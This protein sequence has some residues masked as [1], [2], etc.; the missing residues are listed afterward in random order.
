MFFSF[1]TRFLQKKSLTDDTLQQESPALQLT[2]FQEIAEEADGLFYKNFDLFYQD[3]ATQIDLLVFIP[4][5]GIYFGEKI[6]WD[7]ATLNGAKI[8]RASNK[9]KKRSST[10]L[11]TTETLLHNKLEAILSF[12]STPI[13]RFIWMPSLKEEDFDTLDSSFHELLPKERLIF[14]NTSKESM[15]QK[16]T[17]LITQRNEP[18]ATL[19]VMGSLQSHTLLLPTKEQPYGAFLS[20]EQQLFLDTDYTDTVT[21]LLG[22]YNSG[23]STLLVRKILLLLLKNSEEKIL[24]ITPTLIGGEILRHEL[25]A[26]VEYAILNINLPS[27]SFYTPEALERIEEL[28]DFQNASII[29]CDDS[30]IMDNLLIERLIEHRQKRWLLLSAQS[31]KSPLAHSAVILHNQYQKKIPCKRISSSAE[32]VLSTLLSEL[33]LHLQST[34]AE[35]IMVILPR[36]HQLEVYKKAIEEA[37]HRNSHILT[38]EFSLQYRSLDNLILSLPENTYGLHLP[39]IYI[40]GSEEEQNYTY[41]LSRASESATIISFSNPM[42]EHND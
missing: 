16:L 7:L 37:L 40:I 2:F 5:R 15:Y 14:S 30:H 3:T 25:I 1:L 38:S 27:L 33:S 18:Y 13:E 11:D 28:D 19:K 12:D 17:A 31:E 32:K 36:A 39:H 9:G 8:E 41:L 29:I 22:E 42:G 24:I 23:K 4:D 26:L 20:Q 35:T 10:H 21:T 34:S 6:F